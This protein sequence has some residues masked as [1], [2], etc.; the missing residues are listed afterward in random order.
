MPREK[1]LCGKED[2]FR[3]AICIAE[4]DG[5]AAV[6]IRNIA[7]ELGISPMTI[8]NYVDNLKD[9]KK[10]I[11]IN[12]FDRMYSA[13]YSAL[14]QLKGPA[15]PRSF[16]RVIAMSIFRFAMENRIIYAYMFSEGQTEFADDAEVTPF[17]NQLST[18]P[19]R[20]K[21][22]RKDW[23]KNEAGYR[24]LEIVMFAVSYQVA[25]GAKLLTEDEFAQYID[26]YLEKCIDI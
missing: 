25:A 14:M 2:V 21:A 18:L 13:V 22:T 5:M 4:R 24:M 15:D 9:I 10:R 16:C 20:A 3:V 1:I 26:F 8:Y 17:F 19:Q 12:G 7:R 11:V 23:E 6:S